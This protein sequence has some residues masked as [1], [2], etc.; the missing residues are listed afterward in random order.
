MTIFENKDAK[1]TFF[2][3]FVNIYRQLEVKLPSTGLDLLWVVKPLDLHHHAPVPGLPQH[4]DLPDVRPVAP[5]GREEDGAVVDVEAVLPSL[6]RAE[7]EL[8]GLA[9]A[10]GPPVPLPAPLPQLA[11]FLRSEF[12]VGGPGS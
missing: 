11:P 3:L 10:A 1:A 8:L 5:A 6:D 7:E 2:V 12:V 4:L 9:L